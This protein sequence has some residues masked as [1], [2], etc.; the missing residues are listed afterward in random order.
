MAVLYEQTCICVNTANYR[1]EKACMYL[2]SVTESIAMK[3]REN[4]YSVYKFQC[5][6]Y[7]KCTRKYEK[8]NIL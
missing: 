3:R 5:V 1:V 7:M 6:S 2:L 8:S 4:M